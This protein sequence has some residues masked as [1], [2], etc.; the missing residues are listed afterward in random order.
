MEPSNRL[1]DVAIVGGGLAGVVALAYARR[2]GLDAIVLE[3]QGRIGG[4]WRDLPAWQDIQISPVDWALGDL[5]IDG[6]EA[7]VV[8]EGFLVA[9]GFLQQHR[10]VRPPP[11][12]GQVVTVCTVPDDVTGGRVE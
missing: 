8:A 1:F 9:A 4:L 6:A 2:A 7:D 5:P 12:D 3:S 10:H 11:I